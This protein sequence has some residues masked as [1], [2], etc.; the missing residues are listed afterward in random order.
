MSEYFSPFGLIYSVRLIK[1]QAD[2]KTQSGF[3]N[4][5]SHEYALHAKNAM[6]GK[7]LDVNIKHYNKRVTE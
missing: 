7:E 5:T 6:D 2:F 3:V 1:P 4:F